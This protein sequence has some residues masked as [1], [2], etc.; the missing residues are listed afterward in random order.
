M[1]YENLIDIPYLKDGRSFLGADCYG[2]AYLFGKQNGIDFPLF[3]HKE[4]KESSGIVKTIENEKYKF[5]NIPKSHLAVGDLILFKILGQ[6]VHIAVNVE[7]GIMLHSFEGNRYSTVEKFIGNQ[8]E[9]RI[10][11]IWRLRK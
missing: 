11:S 6:P 8:W 3:L 10:D 5:V 4:T 2:V 7:K 1:K 9:R